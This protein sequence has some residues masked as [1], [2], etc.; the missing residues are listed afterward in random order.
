MRMR[1]VPLLLA[2]ALVA[3]CG[4]GSGGATTN[5]IARKPARQALATAM[6]AARQATS[7]HVSGRLVS[8]QTPL[9]LDLTLARGKGAKGNVVQS[10]LS[11]GLVQ[12][13]RRI[14]IQGSDAFWQHYAPSAADVLR[15]HWIAAPA[16]KGPF[17]ELAPLTSAAKLF[18][19]VESSHGRL[20]N[21]GLTT[22]DGH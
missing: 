20:V 8:G 18:A 6:H 3:G 17:A 11:F 22:F 5:R 21:D 19:L 9:E 7:V 13:G 12:V 15:G 1:A 10:G 4:G 2:A 14:Y 16:G